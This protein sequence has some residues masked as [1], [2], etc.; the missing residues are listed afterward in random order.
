MD[1]AERIAGKIRKY[2]PS[3]TLELKRLAN[4]RRARGLPVFDFGLGETKGELAAPIR[5]AAVTAYREGHTGYGDPAGL[6]EL[7]AAVPR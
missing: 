4:E 6:P 7:R 5:E 3:L 1:E 2:R